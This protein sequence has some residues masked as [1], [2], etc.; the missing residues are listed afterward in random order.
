MHHKIHV[1]NLA[2]LDSDD[3]TSLRSEMSNLGLADLEAD[4]K[5]L[6]ELAE[7][8]R[9][10]KIQ[11]DIREDDTSSL[12]SF[13]SKLSIDR[14]SLIQQF[15]KA[16]SIRKE[17]EIEGRIPPS[18][19]DVID[20]TFN[21]SASMVSFSTTS[22]VIPPGKVKLLARKDIE[23]LQKKQISKK[24]IRVKGEANAFNRMKKQNNDVIKESVGWDFY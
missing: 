2:T 8:V 22:S 7:E 11:D 6:T 15:K 3:L 24:R 5:P 9:N 14:V 13:N 21:D 16:R 17:A 20:D 23:K 18:L 4:S 1:N 12:N 10:I 19:E